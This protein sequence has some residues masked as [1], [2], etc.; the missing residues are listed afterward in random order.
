[1]QKNT[2]HIEVMPVFCVAVQ[3]RVKRHGPIQLPIKASGSA[4][5]DPL[6]SD[7]RYAFLPMKVRNIGIFQIKFQLSAKSAAEPMYNLRCRL[8]DHHG[9]HGYW[10]GSTVDN[11]DDM[12]AWS[13][14]G[15]FTHH[16]LGLARTRGE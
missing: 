4:V 5:R 12:L 9:I 15:H 13:Q 10:S 11:V 7:G 6:K 1:M 3:L 2:R 8:P 16:L 14:S